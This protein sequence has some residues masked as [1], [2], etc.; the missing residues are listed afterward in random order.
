VFAVAVY[1]APV[2][3]IGGLIYL[4]VMPILYLAT[5]PTENYKGSP[6]GIR[7]V[8]Q[9]NRYFVRTSAAVLW[10]TLVPASVF[11]KLS[12]LP[13]V[14][15]ILT[16][17]QFA[18]GITGILA[19]LLLYRSYGFRV[20]DK[21]KVETDAVHDRLND[22]FLARRFDT[23]RLRAMTP[24][25]REQEVRSMS[26]VDMMFHAARIQIQHLE[27]KTAMETLGYIEAELNGRQ[28]ANETKLVWDHRN[29]RPVPA[30][31]IEPLPAAAPVPASAP[32]SSV[33]VSPA[34][35][36]ASPVR[37][38]QVKADWLTVEVNA[39]RDKEKDL[40]AQE[41]DY[42][43][44]VEQQKGADNAAVTSPGGITLDDANLTITIKVDGEGMPLPLESQ[45]AA[46]INI[47]GLTPVIRTIEP[48]S[49][50]N[51]PV[52]ADFLK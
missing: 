37:V 11:V 1:L 31:V 23:K 18:M 5:K 52:L 33:S 29:V 43:A 9:F 6:K 30:G 35:P 27:Y 24:E 46:M 38:A 4:V 14:A 25:E 45:D 40:R 2:A 50:L 22:E 10:L 47:R 36:V 32:V 7:L 16:M 49:A 3:W 48:V 13:N 15:W 51:M 41:P 34:A 19:G 44:V 42:A 39:L 12:L 28:W 20:G 17:K 26:D 21:M 8:S